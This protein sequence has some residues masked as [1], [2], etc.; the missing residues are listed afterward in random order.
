MKKILL[1]LTCLAGCGDSSF[2]P[3]AG[4]A[5]EPTIPVVPEECPLLGFRSTALGSERASG[6]VF[7][8]D[9]ATKEILKIS[10]DGG[11]S[12]GLSTDGR[13]AAFVAPV[14][15]GV[16]ED[17]ESLE[18]LHVFVGREDLGRG[19]IVRITPD[20]QFVVFTHAGSVYRWDR[21][22]GIE[23]LTS[24]GMPAIS[25][26]GQVLAFERP[27]MSG[28]AIFV[29]DPEGREIFLANGR[30][31]SITP[32]G[33]FV[34]WS[35]VG[36]ILR[37]D[38]EN[39]SEIEITAR[40]RNAS[41]ETAEGDCFEP[42]LSAGGRFV[43]FHSDA[44]GEWA[45]YVHDV[46]ASRSHRIGPGQSPSISSGGRYVAYQSSWTV[47]LHDRETGETTRVAEGYEARFAGR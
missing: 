31:P 28:T 47:L 30:Y 46:D 44:G 34:A 24:G 9:P 33:R 14:A 2:E 36:K 17:G 40:A 29:R 23:R 16:T 37:Y 18:Y 15:E 41:G 32:D 8:F 45:V 19:E 27:G 26:D 39:G 1:A 25:S 35:A 3:E 12:L 20:G 43:A 21:R 11:E 6:D 38:R 10:P 13:T 7:R 42:H 4:P 22:S 5:P